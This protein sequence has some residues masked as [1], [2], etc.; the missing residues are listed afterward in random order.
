MY[1]L[2]R[3]NYDNTVYCVL[4]ERRK[5]NYNDICTETKRQVRNTILITLEKDSDAF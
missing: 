5:I 4:C 1:V 2:R 3:G